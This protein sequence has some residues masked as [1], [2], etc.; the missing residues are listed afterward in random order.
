M[1]KILSLIRIK[2][3]LS[4]DFDNTK[5][6]LPFMFCFRGRIYELSDLS[7]TFYREFRFCMYSGLY[8]TEDEIFH[9]IN[10]HIKI[11]LKKQFTLLEEFE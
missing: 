3:V 6:Y 8:E 10:S 11:T 7:F 9:P 1:S 5:L 2:T 4:M